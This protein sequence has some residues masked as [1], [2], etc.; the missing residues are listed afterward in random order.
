VRCRI[1]L[2]LDAAAAVADAEA[3]D[4]GVVVV[5]TDVGKDSY[6]SLPP[7]DWWTAGA[8]RPDS[9]AGNIVLDLTSL[10][11]LPILLAALRRLDSEVLIGSA[12]V[13]S[14][15]FDMGFNHESRSWQPEAR[16]VAS[17]SP[18]GCLARGKRLT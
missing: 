13:I 2:G 10:R 12:I 1:G 4:I 16:S 7:M 3:A 9:L 6:L 5:G 18:I 17:T 14:R 15:M 8:L 11:K